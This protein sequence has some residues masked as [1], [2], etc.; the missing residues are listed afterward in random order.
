[1][2]EQPSIGPIEIS[3]KKFFKLRIAIILITIAFELIYAFVYLRP[4]NYIFCRIGSKLEFLLYVMT[5]V[6]EINFYALRLFILREDV[7]QETGNKMFFLL[8]VGAPGIIFGILDAIFVPI[9]LLDVGNCENIIEGIGLLFYL[10]FMVSVVSANLYLLRSFL[11]IIGSS[12]QIFDP[13]TQTQIS[14][15]IT[16]TKWSVG[17]SSFTSIITDLW[18]TLTFFFLGS[19]IQ[20]GLFSFLGNLVDA[21][22]I[23][24]GLINGICILLTYKRSNEVLTLGLNQYFPFKRDQKEKSILDSALPQDKT[25][26]ARK[27][28]SLGSIAKAT[29]SDQYQAF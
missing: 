25:F 21:F 29:K 17:V 3:R 10:G 22:F 7:N 13:Q 12:Q 5:R 8:L 24:G 26:E 18:F 16:K 19:Q 2:K 23:L 27:A 20:E 6:M 28:F 4:V 15:Y 9:L 1:M 14:K 11:K